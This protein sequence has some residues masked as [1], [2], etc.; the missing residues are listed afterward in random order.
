MIN[1]ND[2]FLTLENRKILERRDLARIDLLDKSD[3]YF[4]WSPCK[5]R[6]LLVVDGLTFHPSADF[7]LGQFVDILLAPRFFVRYEITLANIL[8][9]PIDSGMLTGDSRIARRIVNF[10]FDVDDHFKAD[11][12]DV[13]F[14]FGIASSYESRG[15]GYPAHDA[16]KNS[17]LQ[18]IAEFQNGGGGLFATGDHGALGKAM[19][20]RV[21][22]ARNM[23]LWQSTLNSVGED[24]VSMAGRYRNDTNRRG[25]DNVSQFNDQSDDIPQSISPVMYTRTSGI[26]RYSFPHP[27][28]CSP[29][30]VIRVMPDHPHEGEC[31]VPTNPNLAINFTAALGQ[32]YPAANDGGARPLPQIISHNHVASGTTSG[33][34]DPTVGQTFPGL[35]AYDG[36]RAGKGIGRVLTDATWHHYVNVNL[37]GEDGAAAADPKGKGFL[38]SPAGQAV[39][40]EIKTFYRNLPVWLS[41]PERI[42]CMNSRLMWSLIWS[43]RVLEAVLTARDI[44]LTK[45]GASTLSLI[46]K[47]ARDVLG[48]HVGHCQTVKLIL[49]VVIDRPLFREIDPWPPF[50]ADVRTLDDDEVQLIDLW[51][52]LDAALGGALVKISEDFPEESGDMTKSLKP[53]AI[54][55]SGRAGAAIALDRVERSAKVSI[56]KLG[57]SLASTAAKSARSVKPKKV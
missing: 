44:G 28:L 13:V 8:N 46:G 50:D 35:A 22:R 56:E 29:N 52:V 37:T 19:C 6:L 1:I 16:L 49:D 40:E 15:V 27:V 11:K 25:H 23:R 34:K 24:M 7:G 2:N 36:H 14:M 33:G 57:A 3:I 26:F 18:R 38:A 32:E 45:V 42:R 21:A 54:M 51:P 47:H 43:D 5:V 12:Y 20:H 55:K 39:F 30:G 41:P 17:E 10:K 31:R 48:R 9:V 53:E 4:R